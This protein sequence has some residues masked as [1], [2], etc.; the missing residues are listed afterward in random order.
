[1]VTLRDVAKH[2]GVSSITVSRVVNDS[3]Y[4]S[5]ATREKVEAAVSE[6]GYVPNRV[7]SNLRSRQSDMLALVLPDITNSF[8]TSIARGVEDEAWEHGY[9]VFVCNTDNNPT[10]EDSYIHRLLQQ[11]V[12]GVILVPTPIS[13][14]ESQL[15]RLQRHHLRTV[16]L[17]RRLPTGIAADVVRSD[18][19]GAARTL[20][21]ELAKAGRRRIAF[22]GLPFSIP[23][24]TDRLRG[25][26][27]GLRD[28]GLEAHDELIR[29]GEETGGTDGYRMVT[30]L[31]ALPEPPDAILLANSRIA[32]SG[33]RALRH[34]NV[35]IPE[36]ITVAA[37]HDIHDMDEFAPKLITAVQ[38]S[39]RMGQLATRL[40]LESSSNGEGPYRE[41]ILEPTI[42]RWS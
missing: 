37:F 31:L 24:S 13:G 28:A 26:R 42:H 3:G 15:T 23:A 2:A 35:A 32:V 7:A 25:F 30:E 16:V 21:K 14:S 6:L 12:G 4:A 20:T 38:P 36:D 40:L 34:A 5:Q 41:I 18:G 8:W 33:L 17:H 10:K 27:D 9:G 11:R 29:S 39:Y 22:V 19:E 1:M